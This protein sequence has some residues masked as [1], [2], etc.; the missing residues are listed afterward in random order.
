MKDTPNGEKKYPSY[1]ELLNFIKTVEIF[2]LFI[3]YKINLYSLTPHRINCNSIQ[4]IVLLFLFD[5]R[6]QEFSFH[7]TVISYLVHLFCFLQIKVV[8]MVTRKQ[9][10]Y[11]H[12]LCRRNDGALIGLLK[13]TAVPRHIKG[14]G[15]NQLHNY[16][17]TT[18]LFTQ[19]NI[20]K[21]NQRGETGGRGEFKIAAVSK[22]IIGELRDLHILDKMPR[23]WSGFTILMWINCL[24][25][26]SLQ[27]CVKALIKNYLSI[28]LTK[29]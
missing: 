11:Y 23:L 16:Q 17:P 13:K 25:H 8:C 2:K 19:F 12:T 22:Y 18:Y 29:G 4:I 1:T 5:S 14:Q 10:S 21:T 27:G 6:N 9:T 26:I 3:V 20:L 15:I 28:P 7:L 24:G